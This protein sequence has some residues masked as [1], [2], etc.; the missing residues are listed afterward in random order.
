MRLPFVKESTYYC[1]FMN[2][3]EREASLEN[4]KLGVQ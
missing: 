1:S 4:N 2:M 3:K